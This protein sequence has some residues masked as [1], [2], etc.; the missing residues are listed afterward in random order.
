ML[1]QRA[2]GGD[3]FTLMSK[4]RLIGVSS[5]YCQP[6]CAR[7][8]R[9]Q[10][11]PPSGS[12]RCG[13]LSS[14]H[15]S[16][17]GAWRH[18]STPASGTRGRQG[19]PCSPGFSTWTSPC[20]RDRPP[21]ALPPASSPPARKGFFPSRRWW[22]ESPPPPGRKKRT[23]ALEIWSCCFKG[24]AGSGVPEHEEPA[25][26]MRARRRP[27]I[28]YGACQPSLG[29]HRHPLRTNKTFSPV[30]YGENRNWQRCQM[31]TLLPLFLLPE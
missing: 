20:R 22:L 29:G 6:Q 12:P 17:G 8:P 28:N 1:L 5:T 27:P 18:T 31:V 21:P 4:V 10:C 14:W 16:W 24:R 23:A 30:I 11:H 15:L 25:E 26:R 2:L 19:W 9:W 7:R 13:R 3:G